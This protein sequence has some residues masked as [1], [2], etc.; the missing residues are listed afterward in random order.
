MCKV[1][2]RPH[3]N[4]NFNLKDADSDRFH[5]TSKH[6][7]LLLAYINILL[8]SMMISM[9]IDICRSNT[10]NTIPSI[11]DKIIPNRLNSSS[12][13]LLQVL[14]N[15]AVIM[16]FFSPQLNS[17]KQTC[18]TFLTIRKFRTRHCTIA[19]FWYQM[20]FRSST[21]CLYY[22]SI[23]NLI[24][25]VIVTPSIVNPGPKSKPL[26]VFYNNV[27]GL[28]NPNDLKSN[29]PRLNMKKIHELHGFIFQQ[30]PDVVILNETWLKSNILSSEVL[31]ATY[32]VFRLDRTEK[33][34]PWDPKQPKKY[35]KGGGGVLIAHRTDIDVK[36][37]KVG[38]IEVQ[39]EIL[40]V[41]MT[42][43]S[44]KKLNISTFYRVGNL[45]ND[46]FEAVQKFLFALAS[47]K[48]LDKHIIVGD[49]NFPE[50]A[51]PD[52]STTNGVHKNFVELFMNDICHSQ[53]INEPTHKGGNILDLIFTNIPEL[54]KD[55]SILGRDQACAS[56]HFGFNFNINL[57]ISHRKMP[58]REIYNFSK[59]DW[60]GLNFELKRTDW[61]F[62]DFSDPHLSWP[63]FK[64]I[65]T[66]LCDKYIPKKVIKN[67]FQPPWYDIDCDKL[68]NEKEKWRAKAKSKD[69][70]EADHQKFRTLRSNF[71]K[72]MDLKK[73]INVEDDDESSLI[74]KKFWK[75]VQSKTKSL[76]IPETVWYKDCYRT[77]PLDQANLFNG[78]FSDQFTGKSDYDIDIEMNLANDYFKDLKFHQL[79]ILLL[80]KDVNPS[81]AAGPDGIHGMV[82]KNCAPSLARP[83]T[84]L[85]NVSF[86][87]GCIPEDWK[88]A[89][90]VPVHKKDDK[91]SVEN[92]RPISL[93]SLI[94]KIFE[95]CIR[96][97]LFSVCENSLDPR[98]HGFINNKSCTTQMVPF[99]HDLSLTLNNKSKTDVIY[100]DFAKAFDSVSHDLILQ[101]LK[102]Q[103]RIDGLML[104]FIR[105]YLAERQQ[106]VVIGGVSSSKLPVNSGVPQGSILGPLLFVLFI[107]DMFDCISS[108]TNISLYADDTKIWREI[109][110]SSDHFTL[111]E[112]INK[113][114]IWSVN[115]KM[116]F[117]PSKCKALAV[118]NKRGN[119]LHNLPCTIF[120]YRLH[121]TY[122]DYVRSQVDLGVTVSNK[123]SWTEQCRKLVA[124]ASSRLGLVMRICHFIVNKKQ[125]RAFYLT[126]VRSIF[127]HCSIIWHPISSNQISEFEAIQKRAIKWIDGRMF[128]HYSD[129]QYLEKLKEFDILPLKFKFIFTDLILFYKIMH[130]IVDI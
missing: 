39:A 50:I 70:T 29:T 23:L 12:L 19:N 35:R 65:L 67:Q 18:S 122:I 8:V 105:S 10:P 89:S 48:K 126:M 77:K 9:H 45:G 129:E 114:H 123:L 21:T 68:L 60:N 52:N 14:M 86:V 113:L 1:K 38:F 79:D 11:G 80:L 97:E 6:F 24:L 31:P 46:N 47:K 71:G 104:R 125:K 59:A 128:D 110:L 99:V 61:H 101:K 66:N 84:M 124:K 5:Y 107:N 102:K 119:I 112:D 88:L 15:C 54:I 13:S 111:Q 76:R 57:D 33:T 36:C 127:E 25:I 53:L 49:M 26:S 34:H 120:Q 72:L 22:L 69:G 116:K 40:S 7:Y 94:M 43:E 73:R 75:H 115:N 117:H 103:F 81:K 95:R 109:H 90:V 82:L 58:K 20:F 37:T 32:K 78:F 98:Q 108:G 4:I 96:K 51:W 27:Q 87:T 56:D 74:S 85:F 30:K 2:K 92:Y 17:H 16:L 3:L 106:Q 130:A 93:T 28:I 41:N 63:I 44:G 83:L 55:I 121:N 42:L 64:T 91:G 118:T 62:L 100:F